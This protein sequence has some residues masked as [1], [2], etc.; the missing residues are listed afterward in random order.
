MTDSSALGSTTAGKEMVGVGVAFVALG[1]KVDVRVLVGEVPAERSGEADGALVG[2]GR[3][4]ARRGVVEHKSEFPLIFPT[5]L[6]HFE[7]T[8]FRGGFP[9]DV[10]RGVF[11]HVLADAVKGVAA[12]ADEGF[13]L[14]RA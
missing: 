14:V 7:R 6:T 12:A 4:G 9:I 1:D 13:K 8:G 11:R 10:T 2:V 5:E 3:E